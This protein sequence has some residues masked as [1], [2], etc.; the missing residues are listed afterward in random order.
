[1]IITEKNLFISHTNGDLLSHFTRKVHASLEPNETPIRFV[2][3]ETN[4]KGF[5][6]ELGI[7]ENTDKNSKINVQSIFNFDRRSHE[8]V[9]SFNLALII[10]T[11]V[12]CDM[13][14]HSGDA[15]AVARL[16]ASISDNLITHP[17]VVNAADINEIPDNGLYVEGSVLTR[18]LMGTIT[19]QKVR[20]NRILLLID[21]HEEPIFHEMAINSASAARV[22]L[23]VDIP[24]TVIMDKSILMRAFFSK[25]GRAIGRIDRFQHLQNIL[26]DNE[27][28]YDAVAIT[29]L[30]NVPE[31]FHKDYFDESKKINVNPWGGVEAMLTHSISSIYNVQ[32]AHSPMMTSSEVMNL[33]VGVVDPR[34]SA[35][36][37]STTYLHCILK[38]LHRAP[39]ILDGT[40]SSEGLI[41][42]NDVSC[43]VIPNSCIGLPVL[44]AIENGIP[45][46]AV[47]DHGVKV[48]NNFSKLPFREGQ[49]HFAAN[50]LEAAGI[51]S[52]L[53]AGI[54]I[55]TL[56]RPF[57]RTKV[58]VNT[59][60]KKGEF[61][62]VMKGSDNNHCK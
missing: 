22:T 19:L 53:K 43:L 49:L 47:R 33:S 25:T 20:K 18:L 14:G 45:V 52:S 21:K 15:G 41:S 28:K 10:P 40:H 11:G 29:T 59:S 55:D 34:K 56:A 17:N 1:M 24:Q 35:E 54:S 23:G 32:S 31:H 5:I 50:Y 12:G 39:K 58:Q 7:L 8:N 61:N 42:I 4:S 27:G 6:C 9:D 3:S 51:A 2:V 16:F 30:I 60:N 13:G 38:G 36:A 57:N 26:K 44:A 46:I 48:K 62:M 37:V